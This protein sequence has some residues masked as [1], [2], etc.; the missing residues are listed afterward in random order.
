M[1]SKYMI[2]LS[3]YLIAIPCCDNNKEGFNGAILASEWTLSELSDFLDE[4]TTIEDVQNE[5]GEGDLGP[6]K[7]VDGDITELV[8]EVR[9]DEMYKNGVRIW[10]L[11]IYFKDGK[12]LNAEIGFAGISN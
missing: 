9:S 3:A 12:L 5:F 8:Y 11:T 6:L 7:S 1:K 4:G 2:V 10:T